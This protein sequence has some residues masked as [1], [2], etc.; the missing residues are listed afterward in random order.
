[1]F[2]LY[3]GYFTQSQVETK[4]LNIS[5]AIDKALEAQQYSFDSGHGRQSK[6][7]PAL[8]SLQSQL[9]FWEDYYQRNYGTTPP[10]FVSVEFVR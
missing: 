3:V 6:T 4:L 2:T 7:N 10:T 8:S 1:M 9:E 5:N